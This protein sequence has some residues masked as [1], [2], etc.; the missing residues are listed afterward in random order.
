MLRIRNFCFGSGSSL[1]LVS[2][3]YP[4]SDVDQKL[5]K[6]SFFVLKFLPSL[7]YKHKK[8]A[9]PQLR[10]LATNKVRINLPDSDPDPLVRGTDP[11]IRILAKK[12]WI[13]NTSHNYLLKFSTVLRLFLLLVN[14]KYAHITI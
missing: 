12:S 10:D 6:T 3:P 2:D 14:L 8:A 1:K 11:Q 5:V 7:I 9:L 4:D 13:H